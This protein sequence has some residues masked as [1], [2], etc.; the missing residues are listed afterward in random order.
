[1]EGRK[2]GVVYK[3]TCPIESICKRN[4]LYELGRPGTRQCVISRGLGIRMDR[5]RC[6]LSENRIDYISDKF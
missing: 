6:Y 4:E 2:G 3:S 5:K 1:M